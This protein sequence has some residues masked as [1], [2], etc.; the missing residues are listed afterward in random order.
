MTP[1]HCARTRPSAANSHTFASLS[2][3][4]D[5]GDDKSYRGAPR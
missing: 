5:D 4:N 1:D 2:D 3:R